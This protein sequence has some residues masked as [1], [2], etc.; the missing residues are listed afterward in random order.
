MASLL[1]NGK[2]I[3]AIQRIGKENTYRYQGEG[4][5]DEVIRD[6]SIFLIQKRA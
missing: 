3:G 5:Q 4:T 1:V 2:P 6:K